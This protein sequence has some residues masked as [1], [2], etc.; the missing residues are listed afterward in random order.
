MIKP[1]ICGVITAYDEVSIRKASELV[2]LFELRF[3]LIG[4]AWTDAA[5]KLTKPW[6]ATNRL[7]CDGGRW[8][9]TEEARIAE[10]GRA[11]IAGADVVDIELSAPNIKQ[12]VSSI[13]KQATCL[14]SYHNLDNTPSLNNLKEIVAAEIAAGADICKV[15]T[16][17]RSLGDNVEVLELIKGFP[18]EKVVAMA[19]GEAGGLSRVMGPLV[20]GDFTY[21]A[22]DGMPPS[23]PGQLT[24]LQLVRLY[25]AL[26]S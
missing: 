14:I 1:R 9:G 7:P 16:T 4:P 26:Q 23:A 2:D 20:G 18:G 19:M 21:C 12:V 25:G 8:E 3:D 11:I 24:A 22:L 5:C 13:K 6:I 10:L 15:A 17:A